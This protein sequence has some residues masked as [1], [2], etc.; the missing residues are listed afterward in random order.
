MNKKEGILFCLVFLFIIL[1]AVPGAAAEGDREKAEKYY[2]TGEKFYKKKDYTKAV[3]YFYTATKFD[4][5]H[6]K[7]WKKI[8]FCYYEMEKHKYAHAAFQKV[9]KIDP[10]DKDVKE[11]MNFYGTIQDKAKKKDEK[12]NMMDPL[13]R[14][15]AAPGWGQ[16]YNEQ[17]AKGI[18]TA[19]AFIVS[20]GMTAYNII[21]QRIKYDNYLT[22]NENHE[23]AY[24]AAQDAYN[25]A[26]IWTIITVTVYAAGIVD[27]AMN[28]N[29]EFIN[30]AGVETRQNEIYLAARVRW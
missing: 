28:Y 22:T 4:E 26:F 3:K 5:K 24:N 20:A 17:Q 8:G 25:S 14:S 13:W 29:T 27:A 30:I 23:I 18:I 9:L 16:F 21:D 7:A 12:R 10:E 11:F 19:C 6:I 1:A 15:A 2:L